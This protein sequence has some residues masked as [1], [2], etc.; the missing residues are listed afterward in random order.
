MNAG[1][2]YT[3]TCTVTDTIED[4]SPTV[5]WLDPLGQELPN[6]VSDVV[7]QGPITTATITTIA[8]VY[9]PLRASHAGDYTCRAQ[10]QVSEAVT[11]TESQINMIDPS[12]KSREYVIYTY[13]CTA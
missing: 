3:V 9:N 6:S 7:V 8:L 10:L 12:E 5:A 11:F 13:K 4:T 2:L 1:S